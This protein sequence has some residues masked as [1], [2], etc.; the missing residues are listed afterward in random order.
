MCVAF[1]FIAA[2][3]TVFFIR[4]RIKCYIAAADIRRMKK[5]M[6]EIE[7]NMKPKTQIY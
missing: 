3:L 6:A 4:R 7:E 5:I 2:F 1:A